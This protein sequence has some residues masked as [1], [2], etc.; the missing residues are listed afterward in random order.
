[1]VLSY[2]TI[3]NTETFWLYFVL[4]GKVMATEAFVLPQSLF[5]L[6]ENNWFEKCWSLKEKF[7][8]K[9]MNNT[10]MFEYATMRKQSSY[11][12]WLNQN[13]G[14]LTSK[15]KKFYV[16]EMM[17]LFVDV[18]TPP[19]GSS[20]QKFLYYCQTYYHFLIKITLTC[21]HLWCWTK[22]AYIGIFGQWTKITK[23][24]LCKILFYIC[25]PSMLHTIQ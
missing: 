22:S 6:N 20:K 13:T 5:M 21:N 11:I 23:N 18:I 19:S 16:P 9:F 3:I 2:L 15:D 25:L 24:L 7:K 10:K 8:A 12:D 1:M 17:H 14:S 4:A